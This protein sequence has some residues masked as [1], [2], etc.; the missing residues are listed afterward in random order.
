MLVAPPRTSYQTRRN[1][2]SALKL[3]CFRLGSF[4]YALAV[5]EVFGVY[6]STPLIPDSRVDASGLI[7]LPQGRV[8]LIDLRAENSPSRREFGSLVPVAALVS[9]HGREIALAFDVADEV[10]SVTARGLMN[11]ELGVAPLP[12]KARAITRWGDVFWLDLNQMQLT[13][14]LN[15]ED[16]S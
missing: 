10:I 12:A 13:E 11:T 1:S 4:R 2:G 9:V 15:T 7:Q 6:T 3:V 8:P 5:D 16:N 14:E